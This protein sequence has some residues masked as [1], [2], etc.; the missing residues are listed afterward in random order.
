MLSGALQEIDNTD[1]LSDLKRGI[2]QG[3][4][5]PSVTIGVFPSTESTS[6]RHFKIAAEKLNGKFYLAYFI[7]DK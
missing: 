4:R 7:S 5:R 3:K 2:F 1:K 6:F